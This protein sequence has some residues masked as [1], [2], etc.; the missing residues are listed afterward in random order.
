MPLRRADDRRRAQHPRTSRLDA[1]AIAQLAH[2]VRQNWPQDT[3]L[4]FSK[5]VKAGDELLD[6]P[7]KP[8]VIDS[9]DRDF[10]LPAKSSA[11]R[12]TTDLNEGSPDFE[13]Q[14]CR[15]TSGTPLP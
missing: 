11:R 7:R 5:V 13:W 3:D 9:L 4:E 8:L 12:T 10:T 1:E 2:G 15:P 14:R 6:G